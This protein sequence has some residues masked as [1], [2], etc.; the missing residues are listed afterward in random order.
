MASYKNDDWDMY[1][2]PWERVK[3]GCWIVI[4]KDGVTSYQKIDN[5][6]YPE[7]EYAIAKCYDILVERIMKFFEDKK[8]Y[9]SASD[10]ALDTL[11]QIRQL[12]IQQKN[13][14]TNNT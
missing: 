3:E 14:Y 9:F 11:K 6:D 5:A 4:K 13:S 8:G 7:L 12:A 2:E 10:L 1:R